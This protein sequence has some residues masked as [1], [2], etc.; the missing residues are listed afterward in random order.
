MRTYPRLL[1]TLSMAE[2]ESYNSAVSLNRNC[3]ILKPVAQTGRDAES[4]EAAQL[5]VQSGYRQ[6]SSVLEEVGH[7]DVCKKK[8]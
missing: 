6:T 2:V 4:P 7:D 1:K 8:W 5:G 3:L